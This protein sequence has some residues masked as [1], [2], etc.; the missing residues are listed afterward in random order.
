MLLWYQRKLYAA[1]TLC[2]NRAGGCAAT[3][4]GAHPHGQHIWGG[5]RVMEHHEL[6]SHIFHYNFPAHEQLRSLFGGFGGSIREGGSTI[7]K[8]SLK[9]RDFW[10][11]RVDRSYT[12]GLAPVRRRERVHGQLVALVAAPIAVGRLLD[13]Q[14]HSN[15]LHW[16]EAEAGNWGPSAAGEQRTWLLVSLELMLL[17]WAGLGRAGGNPA[18]STTSGVRQHQRANR[19]LVL[20]C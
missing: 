6:G 12:L 5:Q 16:Q 13:V 14:P 20:K 7:W 1:S 18:I 9:C 10:R 8:F 15:V 2:S 3:C 11:W 4:R 17:Q 19:G